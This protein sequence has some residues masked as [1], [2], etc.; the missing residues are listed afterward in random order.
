MPGVEPGSIIEYRWRESS[1]QIVDHIR[2]DFQRDIPVQKITYHLKPI[3]DAR[4]PYGMRTTAFHIKAAPFVREPDGAYMISAV[5]IPSFK[6]EPDMP[7]HAN[8]RPW[9]L[10]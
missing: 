9:M 10:V 8:V 6:E 1:E 4:F 3:D 2:L 5:D 7:A